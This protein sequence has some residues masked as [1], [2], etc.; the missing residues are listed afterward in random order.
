MESRAY[1]MLENQNTIYELGRQRCFDGSTYLQSIMKNIPVVFWICLFLISC[2]NNRMVKNERKGEPNIYST[3]NDDQEMNEA[4]AAARNTL[5]QFKVALESNSYDTSKFF[6][7]VRF[8]TVTG[9][10]H[11]W[12]TSITYHDGNYF[13]II[14]NLPNLATQKKLGEKYKIEMKDITDWMYVDKGVLQGGYTI[15]LIRNR[16]SQEERT[17][18]DAEFPYK[19][20]N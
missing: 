19:V 13:G 17:K 11:I 3:P 4:I 2:G 16:M 12:S 9:A 8:K 5:E 20:L 15:K 1:K 7:K 10:E 18:F 14:D 6:L